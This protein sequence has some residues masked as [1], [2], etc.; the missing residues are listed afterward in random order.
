MDRG[1]MHFEWYQL[2]TLVL[3]HFALASRVSAFSKVLTRLRRKRLD[4]RGAGQMFAWSANI[5]PAIPPFVHI[6]LQNLQLLLGAVVPG[7]CGTMALTWLCSMW[8]L[9]VNNIWLR[10]YLRDITVRFFFTM[11]WTRWEMQDLFMI[12]KKMPFTPAIGGFVTKFC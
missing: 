2:N 5:C 7:C 4:H 6:Y 3:A 10:E 12:L 1:V 8:L 9:G 11:S